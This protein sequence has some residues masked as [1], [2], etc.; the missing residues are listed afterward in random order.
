MKKNGNLF[1]AHGNDDLLNFI[2]RDTS[3]N[4]CSAGCNDAPSEKQQQADLLSRA[5]DKTQ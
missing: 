5:K 2:K 1:S 4:V 3:S